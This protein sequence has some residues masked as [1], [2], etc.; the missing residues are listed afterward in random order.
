M[1]HESILADAVQMPT[2]SEVL[3]LVQEDPVDSALRAVRLHLGM[4]IGFVS[5][6][7]GD[8]RIFRHVDSS[9]AD[10]PIRAG[11]SLSMDAGYCRKVVNGQLPELIPDTT[12]VPDAMDIP[13]TRLLPIGAHMSV[14]IRLSDGSLYGTFCCFSSKPDHSLQSRD[15]T[16]MRAVAQMVAYQVEA[17]VMARREEQIIRRRIEAVITAGEPRIAY[18]PIVRLGDMSIVGAEALSRFPG[19]PMEGPDLW[20]NEASR[21]GLRADMEI[22]AIMH[23]LRGF[24]P[25]WKEGWYLSLNISPQTVVERDL[26]SVLGGMPIENI[27]LELTEHERVEDYDVLARSLAGLRARGMRVAVDDAG[28]GYSSL[29]HVLSIRPDILKLDISLTEG[30]EADPVRQALAAS[31]VTFGRSTGCSV[32]AEGVETEPQMNT[33]RELG[34]ALGQGYLIARPVAAE[35]LKHVF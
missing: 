15:L 3:P 21:V 30:I 16:T 33:L 2:R 34:I 24:G 5:E 8:E 22:T 18:Q 20:F 26:E 28:S 9:L 23:A 6:F 17:K 11:Q 19:A 25:Y 29:R 14:P 7:M 27:V 1:L 4:E 13:E 32:V 12:L 35:S 31:I 10:P